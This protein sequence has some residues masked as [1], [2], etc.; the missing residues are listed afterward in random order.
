MLTVTMVVWN[1][2]QND[3]RVLKEAETLQQA[4]YQVIVYALHT[5]GIT[6]EQET[7][8]S[9]VKVV[10]VSRSPFWKSR[11]KSLSINA[12]ATG[13]IGKISL[14]RRILTIIAR[15][16]T[17][18]ML[19][20]KMLQAR[21]DIIHAHDVNT[22]PT[23]YLTSIFAPAPL[24][25]DA[26]EVGTSREGY[27]SFR[28]FVYYIEKYLMPRMAATITTTA[29]RAKFFTRAYKITK[30]LILQNQSRFMPLEKTSKIR[31]TLQLTQDWPIV[32]YQGG[33]QQGRGLEHLIAAAAQIQDAYFVFIGWGRLENMLKQKANDLAHVHFIPKVSLQELPSYT[34][35]A[36]IGIQILENTCFNHFSTDS[37][38]LFEYTMAGLPIIASRFPEIS[39]IMQKYDLGL[40]VEPGDIDA[41]VKALRTLITNPKLRAHY[42]QQA[43]QAAQ[44]LNWER[45]ENTLVDLYK[46]LPLDIL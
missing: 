15:L 22:L 4:G 41:L 35:S 5:P 7:L 36:D 23:A 42:Q 6:K 34:A 11:K 45:Q 25:Y 31:D 26:H 14:K 27:A 40:L 28:A 13:P 29:T 21:P 8:S 37:N 30:P 1:D 39:G 24:V 38:K 3:A 20:I 18:A 9:G 2:F 43:Q 44:W 10:R 32:L 19:G 16:Y 33:L 17:H 46:N 12:T